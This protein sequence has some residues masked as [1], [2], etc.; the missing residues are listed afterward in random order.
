M[1][2]VLFGDIK[3]EIQVYHVVIC[4]QVYSTAARETLRELLSHLILFQ[5]LFELHG[6]HIILLENL[7]DKKEL[8]QFALVLRFK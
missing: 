4:V 7:L 5:G 3:V 6:R 2:F 8:F 1:F